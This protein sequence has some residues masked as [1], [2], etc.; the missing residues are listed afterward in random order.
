[1]ASPSQLTYQDCSDAGG[2]DSSTDGCASISVRISNDVQAILEAAVAAAVAKERTELETHFTQVLRNSE[3]KAAI[4]ATELEAH[5]TQALKDLEAKTGAKVA[6]LE[7]QLTYA[8][9][10]LELNAPCKELK[11]AENELEASKDQLNPPKASLHIVHASEGERAGLGCASAVLAARKELIDALDHT[12]LKT[13]CKLSELTRSWDY[14]AGRICG[15][16]G[17][18]D[19]I[20]IQKAIKICEEELQELEKELAAEEASSKGPASKY[21]RG[22]TPA[23]VLSV[24]LSL[25]ARHKESSNRHS[26]L[27][28]AF[29]VLPPTDQIAHSFGRECVFHCEVHLTALSMLAAISEIL[30]SDP[31]GL[32]RLEHH[33]KH[34]ETDTT[35][36]LS[37]KKAHMLKACREYVR[38]SG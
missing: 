28:R 17:A 37:R 24:D 27:N 35:I 4:K 33:L 8:H 30:I 11:S 9:R 36:E 15:T 19:L 32:Q 10:H 14:P 31:S 3:A 16:M 34:I 6:E 1:M 18:A 12:I 29:R 7:R 13:R 38:R 21:A 22:G 26:R 23:S 20:P 2:S 5:F 25:R